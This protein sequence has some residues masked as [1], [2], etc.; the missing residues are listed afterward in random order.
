MAL[1]KRDDGM[2]VIN[3]APLQF[4]TIRQARGLLNL[5]LQTALDRASSLRD[6]GHK[7]YASSEM[8]NWQDP[9]YV[10]PQKAVEPVVYPAAWRV[11]IEQLSENRF[12]H[13]FLVDGVQRSVLGS[14]PQDVVDRLYGTFDP[15]IR[16]Y[17][18]SIAPEPVAEVVI[19][20][21]PAIQLVPKKILRPGSQAER[22][23][24]QDWA[25]MESQR[26][27]RP[28]PKTPPAELDFQYFYETAP[29]AQ[30][31]KRMQTDPEFYA[32]LTRTGALAHRSNANASPSM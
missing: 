31:K 32:W 19:P 8:G 29:T 2:F 16:A 4:G 14:S 20:T 26:E 23:T 15:A 21:A 17:L 13:A 22:M 6:G 25:E 3:L 1:L 30:T 7:V 10:A 28:G 18:Q 9:A 11:E 12:R 24:E 27:A 5:P